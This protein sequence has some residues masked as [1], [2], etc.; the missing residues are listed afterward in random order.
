MCSALWL[1]IRA[2]VW[3]LRYSATGICLRG[4]GIF[5][6]L[7]FSFKY[8][9]PVALQYFICVVLL[10]S[11]PESIVKTTLQMYMSF[12]AQSTFVIYVT[13]YLGL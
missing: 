6:K 13:T 4:A 8:S 1:L 3:S 2:S 10:C 9:E 5:S 7:V 11:L 12:N